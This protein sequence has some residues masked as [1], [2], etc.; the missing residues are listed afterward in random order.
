MLRLC[1]TFWQPP[2]CSAQQTCSCT[3]TCLGLMV[4]VPAGANIASDADSV[5]LNMRELAVDQLPAELQAAGRIE[6]LPVQWRK[7]L[8]FSVSLAVPCVSR[9]PSPWLCMLDPAT[10]SRDRFWRQ[11]TNPLFCCARPCPAVLAHRVT[12]ICISGW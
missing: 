2:L 8:S 10:A 4:S 7:H 3:L 1:P 11:S 5:R 9:V 6:V 12:C